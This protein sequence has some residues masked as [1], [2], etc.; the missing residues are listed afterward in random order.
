LRRVTGGAA[1]IVTGL[2]GE[3]LTFNSMPPTSGFADSLFVAGGGLGKLFKIHNSGVVY[4]W[5]IAPPTTGLLAAT[6]GAGNL[7]GIY[8]Y[9]YTFY[10]ST[11]GTESNPFPTETSFTANF[12]QVALTSIDVSTDAQVT[13]RRIYRTVG[14]GAIPFLLTE[15]ADNVT[16]IYTDNI[17]DI[18]LASQELKFDNTS[19]MDASFDFRECVNM[20]HLGR[21]WW[22]RDAIQ[23]H[24]GRIYYSPVGRAEAV[25]GYIEPG[26]NEDPIRRI[27]AWN[28][29]LY[30]FSKSRIFEVVGFDEPF[31]YRDITGAVGTEWLWTVVPTPYGIIYRNRDDEFRNFNG[32]VSA[33][34]EPG[35]LGDILKGET[36][37]NF[38]GGFAGQ[39]AGFANEEYWVGDGV[40][41]TLCLFLGKSPDPLSWREV[42]GLGIKAF[43]VV[44]TGIIGVSAGGKILVFDDI[45]L[46]TDDGVAIPW[47][48][49]VASVESDVTMQGILQR[50]VFEHNTNNQVITPTLIMDG[51]NVVLPTFSSNIRSVT[52]YAASNFG[53]LL[54]VRMAGSL[55]QK[56]EIFELALDFY[57]PAQEKQPFQAP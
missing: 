15:I 8:K 12:E 22:T 14:N 41:T 18:N 49:E 50:I 11:T 4:N 19:P 56:V 28:G 34:L 17:Q 53:R 27:V 1:D 46:V 6:G 20:P 7:K 44:S 21:M 37:E 45:S 30:G 29:A 39:F 47:E 13:R 36:L 40:S 10:N 16:T 24:Q 54:G 42:G 35:A 9:Y 48:I 31:S 38:T 2:N 57:V 3:N 55:T 32:I 5:G 51:G 26:S 52:E 33:P 43:H 25:A 23:G